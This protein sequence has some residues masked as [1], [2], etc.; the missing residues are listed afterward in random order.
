MSSASLINL[1]S[2]TVNP[3]SLEHPSLI[4][5]STLGGINLNNS[6]YVQEKDLIKLSLSD[7]TI[8]H[9]DKWDTELDAK[10]PNFMVQERLD[11]LAKELERKFT[12]LA[13]FNTSLNSNGEGNWMNQLAVFLVKLPARAA[14]NIIN[15]IYSIIKGILYT[16]VHPLKSVNHLGH[17]LALLALE[18]SKPETYTKIGV[19]MIGTSL[20][21]CLMAGNPLSV[22]GLGIG[23]AMIVG[24]LSFGALKA[25]IE[26]DEQQGS[27]AVKLNLST[28]LEQLPESLVT[29]FFMGLLIGGIRK[30]IYEKQAQAV[31]EA[32]MEKANDYANKIEKIWPAHNESVVVDVQID[33]SGNVSM[34]TE[35]IIP[36]RLIKTIVTYEIN[37]SGVAVRDITIQTPGAKD[38][39]WLNPNSYSWGYINYHYSALI[40]HN[41]FEP[42]LPLLKGE[43]ILN[44]LN[45]LMAGCGTAIASKA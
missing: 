12:P 20:G 44:P 2:N 15:L 9:L 5:P 45:T 36:E 37:S 29:S 19:G 6:I 26:A 38:I 24:G 22:I 4:Q 7:R 43:V 1:S 23:A 28:Q 16:A 17:L 40:G 3:I 35:G 18:L 21:H 8:A 11:Q 41:S 10:I 13:E 33:S 27:A 34:K 31:T 25:A 30:A 39:V 42:L 32:N 14:R